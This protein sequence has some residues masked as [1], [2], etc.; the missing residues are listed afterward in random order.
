MDSLHNVDARLIP[1]KPIVQLMH[2]HTQDGGQSVLVDRMQFATHTVYVD[3][4]DLVPFTV[5][6]SPTGEVWFPLYPTSQAPGAVVH[7]PLNIRYLRVKRDAGAGTM[8]AWVISGGI[9]RT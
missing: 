2:D 5:E 9:A 4:P 1:T 7:F 3:N 8:N 6:A